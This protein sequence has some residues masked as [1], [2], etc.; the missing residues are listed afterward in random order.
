[1]MEEWVKAADINGFNIGSVTNP[2]SWL[3]VAE[4]L[5]LELLSGG[6]IWNDYVVPNGT[7]MENSYG[8]PE[9]RHLRDDHYGHTFKYGGERRKCLRRPPEPEKSMV[10]M[11]LMTPRR[12]NSSTSQL[13]LRSSGRDPGHRAY[14]ILFFVSVMLSK[15]VLPLTK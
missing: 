5:V 12:S 6:L 15:F 2:G 9:Q 1:M 10:L 14:I 4:L 7:S 8:V 13:Q 11:D 3:D